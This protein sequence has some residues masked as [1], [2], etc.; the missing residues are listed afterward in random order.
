MTFL[1]AESPNPTVW[2]IGSIL[3]FEATAKLMR[4][5]AADLTLMCEDAAHLRDDGFCLEVQKGAAGAEEAS[6]AAPKA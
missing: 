4:L 6:T 2:P 5:E 1:V 3:S